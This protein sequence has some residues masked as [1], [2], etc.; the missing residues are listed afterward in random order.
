MGKGIHLLL[1]FL[2]SDIE[3]GYHFIFALKLTFL[4]FQG[5]Y[6]NFFSLDFTFKF[7]NLYVLLLG[8][9]FDTI[10]LFFSDGL[11]GLFLLL[12]DSLNDVIFVG[13]KNIFNF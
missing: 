8:K 3:A 2:D 10:F 12:G 6:L 5:L 9:S 7:R 11:D 4:L 1:K 13:L